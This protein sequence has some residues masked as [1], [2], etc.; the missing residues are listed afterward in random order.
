VLWYR[1]IRYIKSYTVFMPCHLYVYVLLYMTT[2]L[3]QQQINLVWSIYIELRVCTICIYLYIEH[4]ISTPPSSFNFYYP[5]FRMIS[6]Y[7]GYSKCLSLLYIHFWLSFI[8]KLEKTF[9]SNETCVLSNGLL[10]HNTY[11]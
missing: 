8:R 2:Y 1:C 11:I 5:L 7:L 9:L 3:H 10:L 4:Y 6:L